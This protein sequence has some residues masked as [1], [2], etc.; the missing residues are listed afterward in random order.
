MKK[1]YFVNSWP[2]MKTAW[3]GTPM[4]LYTA[5]S[6]RLDVTL[7]DGCQSKGKAS[8]ILNGLTSGLLRLRSAEQILDNTPIPS[9]VPVFTFGE[10]NSRH[11]KNTY[12]YQDLS[13]DYQ[14]RLRRQKHPAAPYALKKLVPTFLADRKNKKTRAF[15]EN[16]A[17]VFTMSRWLQQDLVEN[18]GLPAGKVH[19]AGGGSNID[20]SK[21]DYSRKEGNKFLF[22]GIDWNRKNGDLVVEAFKQLRDRYPDRNPQLYIAGPT[23]APASVAGQENIT[24]L[25]RLSHAQLVDYYN[26]CDYYVMPSIYEAYGLVFVEALCFGLPCIGKNFCAMPEFI[27]H[28]E[29]GYLLERDDTRELTGLMEN[30]LLNGAEMARAVQEKRAYYLETY[31]WDTVADRIIRVLQKDGCLDANL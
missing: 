3:S 28:G 13:T 11:A 10:Y 7:V 2:D 25:G 12:C 4:G 22:V 8:S 9:G 20:V 30:L 19:H 18:T 1:L 16:C 29:N 26:L 21:V 31:A 27:Q 5:L 15:Y 6:K 23:E 17:G 14:L 24:F